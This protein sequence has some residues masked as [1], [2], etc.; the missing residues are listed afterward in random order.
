MRRLEAVHGC[1]N[2]NL[3]VEDGGILFSWS[4]QGP[5]FSTGGL[6]QDLSIPLEL[7]GP[8]PA[9]LVD[10]GDDE[11][12]WAVLDPLRKMILFG[13]P[14]LQPTGADPA[15]T[16]VYGLVAR[17]P[18]Q[19]RWVYFEIMQRVYCAGM[20]IEGA[21]ILGDAVTAF[22]SL[23][24]AVDSGV[25]FYGRQADVAWTQ[26]ALGGGETVQMLVKELEPETGSYGLAHQVAS[27]GNPTQLETATPPFLALRSWELALRYIRDARTAPGYESD[28]ADNWTAA[29]AAGAKTTF[30]TLCSAPVM[31]SPTWQRL[32]EDT[33]QI[34][35]PFS[36]A[37]LFVG[38]QLED[39]PNGTDSWTVVN[40][41][42]YSVVGANE[43][44]A[45]TYTPPNSQLGQT[46]YYRMRAFV[47]SR[48]GPYSNVVSRVIGPGDDG[49][50]PPGV[51]PT[52]Y[53]FQWQ[54]TNHF[55]LWVS[56]PV[57]SAKLEVQTSPDG[58]TAW[59]RRYFD[60]PGGVTPVEILSSIAVG[61]VTWVRARWAV[62]SSG[63]DD[64]GPWSTAESILL[65]NEVAPAAATAFTSTDYRDF[66]DIHTE[67][68]APGAA[69]G[70]LM[71]YKLTAANNSWAF[72]EVSD[73]AVSYDFIDA[74]HLPADE[75]TAYTL[76]GGAS[77][78][79]AIDCWSYLIIRTGGRRKISSRDGLS[80]PLPPVLADEPDTLVAVQFGVAGI[81]VEWNNNLL[82]GS[83]R[84][85]VY[86]FNT[87]D[88]SPGGA[89]G[90]AVEMTG[91]GDNNQ[92][93]PQLGYVAL[94]LTGGITVRIWAEK[95]IGG[96]WLRTTW[97]EDA[98]VLAAAPL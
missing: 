6:S 30:E 46:R 85:W 56:L 75:I 62:T 9:E 55:D 88:G 36:L 57:P 27:D 35:Y 3:A 47:T 41:V 97:I 15:R 10:A 16:R 70:R 20:V 18:N 60:V 79:A 96:R 80:T 4:E 87:S 19:L 58:S 28:N 8:S 12:G 78:P 11:Y 69:T 39:S 92:E 31:A 91:V 44:G 68:A 25:N 45:P 43:R 1:V 54:T 53:I 81:Y 83:R 77:P 73:P 93:G 51:A 89:L 48:F 50:T 23:V 98:I 37:E 32:D 40:T 59:S 72:A 94:P 26:N 33:T 84:T 24:T 71:R 7:D 63:V 90:P 13:F 61:S 42:L 74:Y 82:L 17:D 52:L 2:G 67:F 34:T 76:N 65:T 22:A 21:Q 49:P 95:L 38:H 14:V 5:R 29:T 64:F 86:W 66:D